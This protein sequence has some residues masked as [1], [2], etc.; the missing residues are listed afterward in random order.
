VGYI[1]NNE[2]SDIERLVIYIPSGNTLIP[3]VRTGLEGDH[4]VVIIEQNVMPELITPIHP[5]VL[6]VLERI[7][8]ERDKRPHYRRFEKRKYM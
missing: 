7:I 1:L 6:D 4:S 8:E 5:I 2:E 3:A